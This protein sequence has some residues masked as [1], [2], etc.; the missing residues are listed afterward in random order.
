VKGCLHITTFPRESPLCQSAQRSGR[1]LR[2]L[3]DATAECRVDETLVLPV[4]VML[5]DVTECRCRRKRQSQNPIPLP[6][7]V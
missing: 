2:K 5:L 4:P 7:D 1:Y 3:T 6:Y